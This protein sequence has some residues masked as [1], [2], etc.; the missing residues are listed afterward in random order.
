MIKLN[1]QQLLYFINS[2][3][4]VEFVDHQEVCLEPQSKKKI[5]N[6]I[7][8]KELGKYS[9]DIILLTDSMCLY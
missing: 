8:S 7:D 2:I 5:L 1:M 6:R 4:N 3:L 9:F